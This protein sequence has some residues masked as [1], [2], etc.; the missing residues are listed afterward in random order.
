M[1]RGISASGSDSI[2]SRLVI[3]RMKMPRYSRI[4]L[5]PTMIAMYRY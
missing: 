3:K 1:I 4:I 2:Q 5:T